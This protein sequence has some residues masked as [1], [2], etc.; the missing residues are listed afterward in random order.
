[1]PRSI[2]VALA[3]GATAATL[4]ALAVPAA[5]AQGTATYPTKPIRLVMPFPPGPADTLARL[6]AARLGERWKQPVVVE[7]RPGATGT[8]GT[9]LVAKAPADGYTLLFTV[10]LPIVMAPVL[11]KTPYDVLRDLAPI[12]GVGDGMNLFGVHPSAGVN[13]LAEFVAAAKAK[14][15]TLSFASA[16]NA[17]PGHVC[18]E[19]LK[20]A[21]GIDLTHV[22]YKG[23]GPAS[24][25]V[26]AGEVT[27]F[28]G[29][30]PA[31]L[32]HVRSGKLRAM[33]VTGPK[34]SPLAPELATLSST[35]PA[36]VIT[37]WY[38]VFAPAKTPQPIL[39]AARSALRAVWEDAEL[40]Q[41]MQTMGVDATWVEPADLARLIGADQAKWAN[42]I[43]SANIKAD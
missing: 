29:P 13:T 40:K 12:A 1:M 36:L 30:V 31:L 38:G 19:M 32:P 10:D 17:S 24:Q 25:G 5:H 21:A 8:I 18:G 39:D 26:L 9:D 20:T 23:A 37:N 2:V 33:G 34:P 3:C 4:A 16:G 43:K 35:Y 42:V 28:C 6:F 11:F 15:G 27:A 14:P 7:N 22:P 41:R